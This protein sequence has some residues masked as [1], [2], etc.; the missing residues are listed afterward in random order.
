MGRYTEAKCKL[1]RREGE[2]LFL[3][4]EKCFSEKCPMEKR[5]Y[6]AGEHG[7]GW[8]KASQYSIRLRQKQKAK[9]I[10]GIREEQFKRYVEQ[11]KRVKGITGDFLLEMLERRLDNVV[12]R[13]GFASS[14]DQ[15][16]QLI[17][18]G[19]FTVNGRSVDIPSYSTRPGD[20]IELKEGSRSKVGLKASLEAEPQKPIPSWLEREDTKI[21]VLDR[22]DLKTVEHTLQMN[23]IIEF[24]SR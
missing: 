15:A 10:Y 7:R 19:H 16:R 17:S 14:R 18:H 13:A 2:K 23:L 3:K 12:Y 8:A 9:R 21:R 22:P 24:Y 20:V 6:P 5:P 1:C 4:G 11:A